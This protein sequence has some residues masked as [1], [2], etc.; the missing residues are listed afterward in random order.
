VSERRGLR[1]RRDR[2]IRAHAECSAAREIRAVLFDEDRF[3]RGP[4]N[5]LDV[6]ESLC[7][8]IP[9]GEQGSRDRPCVGGPVDD[10]IHLHAQIRELSPLLD[11]RK[12]FPIGTSNAGERETTRCPEQKECN[13]EPNTCGE[14]D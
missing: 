13:Q 14:D 2:L 4:L 1:Q 7:R 9:C 3:I 6:E 5:L 12:V 8:R 11:L 10:E